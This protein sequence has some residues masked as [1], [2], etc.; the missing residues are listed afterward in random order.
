MATATRPIPVPRPRVL[1][2]GVRLFVVR[3]KRFATS[4]CRIVVHRP[5]GPDAATAAVLAKV[6]ASATARHPTRRALADALADLYGATLHVG[7]GKLGDRQLFSANLEWPTAHVTTARTALAQGLE[8]L[9]DVFTRPARE[10]GTPA[11]LRRDLVASE[12]TN[13]LRAHA[14]LKG[15]KAAWTLRQLIATTC[16][17]E[18]FARD[19]RGRAAEA[20][21]VTAE[22]VTALHTEVIR[23]APIDIWFVGD[24]APAAAE[25]AVA[26]HLAW[27]ERVRRPMTAPKAVSMRPARPRPRRRVF[28]DAVA[29][30]RLAFAWRGI[31]PHR[32]PAAAA[33]LA[34]GGVLGGGA[35]GRLFKEL[36]EAQGLCYDASAYYDRSKGL[37]VVELGVDPGDE[38]RAAQGVRALWREVASG[39]L[40]AHAHAAFLE[41]QAHRIRTLGDQRGAWLGWLQQA[42]ALG[43]DPDPQAR[44]ERLRRVTPAALRGVGRRLGLDTTV[45]LRPPGTSG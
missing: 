36:R 16:R 17:G 28:E 30:T 7:V 42:D 21:A 26:R 11:L 12:R 18:P 19:A 24:V 22:A 34:L 8:L 6:L 3:T 44:F 39:H 25:R 38:R 37:V 10:P 5:L 43:L 32:G 35:Y 29:Q 13:L 20:R 9:G 45:V 14:A 40:D 15:D 33:A 31:V 2:P 27:P 4:V 1:A 41:E 23:R